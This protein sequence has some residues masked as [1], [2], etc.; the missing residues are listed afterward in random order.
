ME[1]LIV[2]GVATVVSVIALTLAASTAWLICFWCEFVWGR[3]NK[4][5]RS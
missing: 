2:V 5:F 1:L 4:Y 3:L